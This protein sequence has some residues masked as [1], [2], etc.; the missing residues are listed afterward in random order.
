MNV[1]VPLSVMP[2]FSALAVRFT[3]EEKFGQFPAGV[4]VMMPEFA[5]LPSDASQ[6]AVFV[7]ESVKLDSDAGQSSCT[8]IVEQYT[9]ADSRISLSMT[10]TRVRFVPVVE[11]IFS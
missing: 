5:A 11:Y 3:V 4:R 1:S 2:E 8:T 7:A 6:S 10:F 9:N